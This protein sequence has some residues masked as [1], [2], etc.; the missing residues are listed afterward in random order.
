[1]SREMKQKKGPAMDLKFGKRILVIPDAHGRST[2]SFSDLDRFDAAGKLIRDEKP[3]IVV[4]LGDLADFDPLSPYK[5][6]AA[7]AFDGKAVR[8]EALFRT[9]ILNRIAGPTRHANERHRRGRHKERIHEPV[10]IDL[11]GN[12]EERWRRYPETD[13]LGHDFLQ[14]ESEEAGWIWHPFLKPVDI[15][16]VL[17]SHYFTTGVSRRPA[18][19]NTIL[20]KTHRSCVFGH[21][22]SFGFDQKPVLGGGTISALCAGSFKPPHRTG[23]HEWSGLVMLED[24]KDG[25]FCIRQIPYDHVLEKYGEGDYAQK[26][27]TRRAQAAQD[28]ENARHAYA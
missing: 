14:C 23:E 20:N 28:R 3:D 8:K 10:W 12:H 24:V 15:L 27:R 2:E 26:L 5:M 9:E 17:F 4:S 25:S 16:G 13:L 21:T 7:A 19:V 6:K 22:H 11:E 18:Q 1:M